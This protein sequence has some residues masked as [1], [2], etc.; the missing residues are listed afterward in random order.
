[1]EK[2]IQINLTK[3]IRHSF[4]PTE[5]SAQVI[6][7]GNL[8]LSDLVDDLL[9]DGLDINRETLLNILTQFNQKVSDRVLSGYVVNTGLLSF[10]PIVKGPYAANKY[11]PDVVVLHGENLRKAISQTTIKVI[12][13]PRSSEE[14][15]TKEP[16]SDTE[17]TAEEQNSNEYLGISSENPACGMAFRTWL[18]K[19]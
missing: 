10:R 4:N 17:G 3:N 18:F 14:S 11:N 12:N 9:T 5:Y 1:M 6:I 7:K 2:T 15:D 19:S 8:S 13:D 16:D